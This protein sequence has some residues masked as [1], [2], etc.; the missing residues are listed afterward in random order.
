MINRELSEV[1]ILTN[2]F[3]GFY[4]F[5]FIK[6]PN[7]MICGSFPMWIWWRER[8]VV[9][10][11]FSFVRIL[12]LICFLL[13]FF[14]FF[15]LFLLVFLD[16]YTLNSK[17]KKKKI[18]YLRCTL[19]GGRNFWYSRRMTWLP[20]ASIFEEVSYRSWQNFQI[21]FLAEIGVLNSIE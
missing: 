20:H 1:A 5:T 8:F 4:L 6:T 7:V 3:F 9:A 11:G 14:I 21:G 10:R 17:W 2:F 15:F 19:P 12:I 18:V 16:W 13:H